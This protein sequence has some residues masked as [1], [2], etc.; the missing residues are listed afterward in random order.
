MRLLTALVDLRQRRRRDRRRGTA[1]GLV[2]VSSG[3]LGDTVLLATVFDRL[4]GLAEPG[5]R[6]TL[7]LRRDAAA[8]AFLFDGVAEVECV[9]YARL[10]RFAGYRA[11]TFD[12]LYR[13]HA[14]LA[15]SLDYLRH[16]HL[17]EA[18]VAACGAPTTLAMK[19]RPWAKYVTELRRNQARYTALFDSG[20]AHLD[21]V[22]RWQRF[23]DW[24][25]KA[26]TPPAPIR[27]PA[28]CLPPAA[29]LAVPTVFVQPFSA[30]ARKQV[31]PAFLARLFE[32]VPAGWHIRLTGTPADLE[33]QPAYAALL[34][35]PRVAFD[36]RRFKDL[37][38]DLLAARA[39]VSVDTAMLHLAAAVGVPT[40]G[41][42]SA[43]YVGE[44]VP[45]DPAV[46]PGNVEVLYRPM[47]C[48]GCL[49]ACHLPPEDGMFPCVARL[50]PEKAR[51]ALASLLAPIR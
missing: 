34:A 14:R 18:L 10:D 38:P 22:L 21:K 4:A 7:V 31:P 51:A 43:A 1:S 8:M 11:T 41:L 49:G 47:P 25:L 29:A 26:E 24:L 40:L 13:R 19:P 3:G 6:L 32:V 50:D 45:Y 27:L 23:A 12:A 9:D 48:E 42:A 37:L 44:I 33:R 15:V 2:L 17:D 5:E 20:P 46:A 28:R 30:V 16:P 39:V 35:P 36:G